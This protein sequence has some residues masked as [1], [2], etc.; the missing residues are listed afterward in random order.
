MKIYVLVYDEYAHFEANLVGWVKGRTHE[1]VT[2][3]LGAQEV[4]AAEGF[5]IKANTTID[6]VDVNDVDVFVIPGGNTPSIL[7]SLPLQQLIQQLNEQNKLIGA[8]CYGTLLLAEANILQDKQFTTS[9]TPDLDL[10]EAFNG[11]KFVNTGV[12]VDGNIVTA[13]GEGYVDFALT[14]CKL[15]DLTNEN[16]LAYWGNFFRSQEELVKQ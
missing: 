8:I 15:A 6:Q 9:V 14:I 7:G 4:T 13:K 16:A 3:S 12:A 2:V 5:I 11:E 1:I 10:F